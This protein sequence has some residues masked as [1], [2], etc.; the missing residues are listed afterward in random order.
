MPLVYAPRNKLAQGWAPGEEQWGGPMN[1]NLRQLDMNLNTVIESAS[2]SSPPP[3]AEEGFCYLVA[4]PATAEWVGQERRI[5][6]LFR[7]GWEFFDPIGGMRA[8]LRSRDIFIW[9]NGVEWIDEATGEDVENPAPDARDSKAA[10]LVSV[11]YEPDDG[12]M[13][14]GVAMPQPMVLPAG[15][16]GSYFTMMDAGS[17]FD[18]EFVIK[19]NGVTLGRINLAKGAFSGSFTL[20]N[21]ATFAIGDRLQI[22]APAQSLPGLKNYGISLLMNVLKGGA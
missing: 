1:R 17:P 9:F 22:L 6:Y 20:I 4:G 12:E 16:V 13:L 5:A 11:A 15:A 10:I 21:A 2:W 7:S 8:R 14:V 18:A 3:D 19:R